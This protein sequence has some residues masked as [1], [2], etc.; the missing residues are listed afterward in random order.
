MKQTGSIPY[1][2]MKTPI[3]KHEEKTE[4]GWIITE[5]DH[6]VWLELW[7]NQQREQ[8]KYLNQIYEQEHST[9]YKLKQFLK[10]LANRK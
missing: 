9:R 1:N 4:G 7:L 6:R 10:K 5:M 8:A 2:R 3:Y